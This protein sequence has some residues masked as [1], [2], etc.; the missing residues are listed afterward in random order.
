MKHLTPHHTTKAFT[1]IEVLIALSVLA[2]GIT[3]VASLFPTAALLQKQAVNETLRQNHTRSSDA[4]LQ[5]IGLRN[6]VLLNFTRFIEIQPTTSTYP[7]YRVR[8]DRG[9]ESPELD[10]FALAEVD[11]DVDPAVIPGVGPVLTLT[12]TGANVVDSQVYEGFST[13]NPDGIR[14]PLGMRS[15]PTSIPALPRTPSPFANANNYVEREIFTVP[16]VRQGLEASE[17]FPDWSVYLFILQPPSQL[18]SDGAYANGNYPAIFNGMVCA[19]PLDS[20]Y[21]PKVLRVPVA[22]DVAEPNLITPRNTGNTADINLDGLVKAGELILGDNGKI[23]RIAQLDGSSNQILLAS[24]TLFEPLN[25]RDLTAVWIAPA[26]GGSNQASPLG[27][28]RLLSSSLV[29]L[30]DF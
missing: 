12:S 17:I 4:I 26:P 14:F 21:V 6:N 23:Y 18:R 20:D 15:L 5:G 24:Q 10:V 30:N 11:V 1:L 29:Q 27:D 2:L 28:L 25:E 3:A 7:A 8:A 16:M 13:A 22:W 9:I 19:N